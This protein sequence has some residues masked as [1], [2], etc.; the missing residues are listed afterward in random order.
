MS[1]GITHSN[2]LI[3]MKHIREFLAVRERELTLERGQMRLFD[4]SRE[5]GSAE[6]SVFD[7]VRENRALGYPVHVPQR[8]L[9][10][11]EPG[12]ILRIIYPQSLQ[13]AH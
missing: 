7:A 3:C 11:R 8:P 1:V 4:S 13:P 9:V 5:K 2:R 12:H 6:W 10:T